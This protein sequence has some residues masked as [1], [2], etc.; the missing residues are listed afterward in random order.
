MAWIKMTT[1]LDSDPR[2]ATIAAALGLPVLHVIGCLWKLWATA[3]THTTD[4]RLLRTTPAAI[5]LMVAA[6]GFAHQ[7]IQVDWLS[8]EDG[9]GCV[10]PRFETHNGETAKRRA[11]AATR[12]ARHRGKLDNGAL[13]ERDASVTKCAPR[14]RVRERENAAHSPPPYPPADAV[15]DG[16]VGHHVP[17]VGKMGEA[18]GSP[19]SDSEP[20]TTLHPPKT[21][22]GPQR[23]STGRTRA[24]PTDAPADPDFDEFFRRYPLRIG[25]TRKGD[26]VEARRAWNALPGELRTRWR[27]VLDERLKDP[28]RPKNVENFLTVQEFSRWLPEAA[29]RHAGPVAKESRP[30]AQ[31]GPSGLA[32]V[33]AEMGGAA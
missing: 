6:P 16:V 5:D 32:Q 21:S 25:A 2:V 8:V 24:I 12:A 27:E 9:G 19:V 26:E 10:I 15:G 20:R 33:I 4:G 14:E 30:G 18:A 1:D 3:D 23:G 17:D 11:Q 29:A 13:R 28:T 22:R 7:L 31:T